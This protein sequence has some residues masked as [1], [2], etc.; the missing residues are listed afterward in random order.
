MGIDWN[1]LPD[2]TIEDKWD[3]EDNYEEDY[4]DNYEDD[5]ENSLWNDLLLIAA[6]EEDGSL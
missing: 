5:E 1:K 2:C 3:L 6:L 4:Y